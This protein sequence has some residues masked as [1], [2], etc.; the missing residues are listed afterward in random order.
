LVARR[1]DRFE[2]QARDIQGPLFRV[3]EPEVVPTCRELDIGQICFHRSSRAFSRASA[4]RA[5]RLRRIQA[6]EMLMARDSSRPVDRRTLYP[7]TE[8]GTTRSS[9]KPH[10]VPAGAGPG[11]AERQPGSRPG[12]VTDKAA[13]AGRTL[14][15]ET[16]AGID[17]VLSDAVERDG[18][19][20]GSM[21]PKNR[22]T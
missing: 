4:S 13:A 16:L 18:W 8:A 17:D 10:D 7:G 6:P 3:I 1:R 12:Q 19:L 5:V 15:S 11:P 2:A 9:R 20:L 21:S 22:H 14:S